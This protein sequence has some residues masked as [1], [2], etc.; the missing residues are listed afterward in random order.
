MQT[1]FE[2]GMTVGFVALIVFGCFWVA[3]LIVG[4]GKGDKD[5]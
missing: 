3:M 1:L 5:K 2:I 4:L